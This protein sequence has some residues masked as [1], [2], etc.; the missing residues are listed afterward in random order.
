MH[1]EL[2]AEGYGDIA[3]IGV[4]QIGYEIGNDTVTEGRV[5]PWLQDESDV[6]VWALWTV[7]YRDVIV[8]DPSLKAVDVVNLS[9]FGLQER[10]NF[11]ALKDQL[12]SLEGG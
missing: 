9:D 12:I 11:D 2:V 5:I 7:N 8:V 6:N 4:N 3:L 1:A 10:A